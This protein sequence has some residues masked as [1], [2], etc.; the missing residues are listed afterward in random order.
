METGSSEVLGRMPNSSNGTFLVRLSN[1]D[2]N[3]LAIYKPYRGER[4]LWDFPDGLYRREAAAYLLSTALGNHLVPPT[5]VRHDLEFGVGSLQLFVDA[6]FSR[7]YF[8]LL[9]ESDL[10]PQLIELC[11]FDIVANNS[12]RKA[13]HVLIDA[14]R[15]IWAIDNGLCF[16]N[17][18]K[19]RT[20]IWE[21]GDN[22]ISKTTLMS[23]RSL[24]KEPPEQLVELLDPA[25]VESMIDRATYLIDTRVVPFIDEEYRSYP[26][27]II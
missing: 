11:V 2:D 5:I 13:G 18:P 21:F 4:P 26:W 1:G 6:D 17:E 10:Y 12:D 19:L 27:P 22:A 7:H 16:H 24:V 14:T 9:D 8:D 15:S 25:E 23:L 3:C 20:V